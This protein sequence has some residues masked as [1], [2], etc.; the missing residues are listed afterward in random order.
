MFHHLKPGQRLNY[1][2]YGSSILAE[3]LANLALNLIY[4]NKNKLELK[5]SQIKI[6]RKN[7]PGLIKLIM[8]KDVQSQRKALTTK[9]INLLLSILMSITDQIEKD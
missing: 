5:P 8:A 7:K 4:S 9:L 3:C 2:K 1:V 6:L